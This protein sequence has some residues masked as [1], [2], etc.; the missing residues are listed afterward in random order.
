MGEPVLVALLIADRVI[1]EKNGKKG[2]IG[3]FTTFNAPA[4]PVSFPPWFIY[5]AVTNLAGEHDFALNLVHA[6]TSQIVL[7]ISGK[8]SA[9]S[10]EQMVELV[11][12]V[13]KAVFP[14]EGK[15]DL[16]FQV[17]AAPL[18]ARVLSLVQ[19]KAPP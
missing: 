8:F 18:G 10:A 1:E 17:D 15:Y 16:T 11:I 12:P 19:A 2:I 7:G 5:A 3:T 13:P 14:S 4:F 9:A 6:R